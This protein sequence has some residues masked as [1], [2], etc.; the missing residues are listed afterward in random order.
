MSDQHT[1]KKVAICAT[2]L[3]TCIEVYSLTTDSH[4]KWDFFFVLALVWMLY[5]IRKFLALQPIDYMMFTAFLVMHNLGTFGAYNLFIAGIEYDYYVHFLFGLA[6][7]MILLKSPLANILQKKVFHRKSPVFLCIIILVLG[8]SALHELFEFTGALLLGK[9]E[10]V[11]FI[12]AGDLD[13]WDTQKDMMNNLIG[14]FVGTGY[15]LLR[16]KRE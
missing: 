11:L 9:G 13:P 16:K 10:G 7:S 15:V 4:Y 12:G 2:I 6:A 8:F 5:S 3:L 1:L 14:A